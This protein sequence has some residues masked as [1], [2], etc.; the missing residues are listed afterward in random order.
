[1]NPDFPPS[2]AQAMPAGSSHKERLLALED[3]SSFGVLPPLLSE[4][5]LD[6]VSHHPLTLNQSFEA[7]LVERACTLVY[8]LVVAGGCCVPGYIKLIE[9]MRINKSAALLGFIRWPQRRY[10]EGPGSKH[11]TIAGPRQFLYQLGRVHL[12]AYLAFRLN[13]RGEYRAKNGD[14]LIPPLSRVLLKEAAQH[15]TWLTGLRR[16]TSWT[17]VYRAWLQ[18][19]LGASYDPSNI[20]NKLLMATS[21]QVITEI[22]LWQLLPYEPALL[23]EARRR[24][25]LT[26]PLPDLY[27]ERFLPALTLSSVV[28]SEQG[29]ASQRKRSA[30]NE[31]V[32][33]LDN[34]IAP[35]QLQS[36][37]E[38]RDDGNIASFSDEEF[39]GIENLDE[40]LF[41]LGVE[42][43]P[44]VDRIHKWLRNIADQK[45]SDREAA[46][47]ARSLLSSDLL[48][49]E[50]ASDLRLIL[51]W[52]IEK[53]EQSK[54]GK[55][56]YRFSSVF[57]YTKRLLTVLDGLGSVP[58][59]RLST[60]DL[61]AFLDD[62]AT[63]NAAKAYRGVV[64]DFYSFLVKE[65]L[66]QS[67]QID[68][69]SRSLYFSE[70]YR[71]RDLITEEEFHHVLA[72][73]C[74]Y[75]ERFGQWVR[76][77]LILLRRAGLRCAEASTITPRDFQGLTECRLFIRTSK[78]RA[79]KRVLPLYLL[80]NRREL[81]LVLTFVASVRRERGAD[82]SLMT[83]PDGSSI[84]PE[85]IGRRVV[86][87]LQAGGVYGQTAHGLRH[88]FASGLAAAWWLRMTDR[89]QSGEYLA[90]H[91]WTRGALYAFG[92][93]DIEGRAVE[94][95]DDIRRLLGHADVGV[96]FERYIHILDLIA[97]DAI[98]LAEN[99]SAPPRMS[100][101][102]AAHLIGVTDRAVRHR[103][104]LKER[105][106]P[107]SGSKAATITLSQI[108][109]WLTSR[110][111]RA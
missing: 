23:L 95:A 62:Y 20:R 18:Y 32:A 6:R 47:E 15:H 37:G 56:R 43:N 60:S 67:D 35:L 86:K 53:L 106:E 55:R 93:P 31:M 87:L 27:L 94:H 51:R 75:K 50:L 70:G 29:A 10:Y 108:E 92:R 65:G 16:Q 49:G 81:Q 71:E 46:N 68:F 78:T 84:K 80:L 24:R 52:F 42:R 7:D 36:P 9:G 30:N 21:A 90:A 74:S 14:L 98:R 101:T 102:Y 97:A 45:K 79:G 99:H 17:G 58:L 63:A 69:S 2:S 19:H 88:A 34:L 33:V 83:A 59:T 41:D 104:K 76:P 54:K 25:L 110:L 105:G 57:T 26:A 107:L 12:K 72:A 22:A 1:M 13:G 5:L 4:A 61:A 85:V 111:L 73:S 77:I 38:V 103:F 82:V 89:W 28:K 100:I 40:D 8:S 66:A 3:W 39:N 11:N 96:T 91:D 48:C 109:D 44:A 64:R